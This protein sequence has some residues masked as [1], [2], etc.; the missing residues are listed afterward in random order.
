MQHNLPNGVRLLSQHGIQNK[1]RPFTTNQPH[2]IQL[3]FPVLMAAKHKHIK[4]LLLKTTKTVITRV[5]AMHH[6]HTTIKVSTRILAIPIT[7]QTLG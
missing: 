6:R 5:M 2:G 1:P 7:H 3:V 4:Q